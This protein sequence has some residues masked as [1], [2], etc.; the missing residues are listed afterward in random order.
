MDNLDALLHQPLRTQIAAYLA[1]SGEA[2]FSELRRELAVSDGNLESHLKKLIAAGYVTVR[3]ESGEGR[4]QSYYAL[5][6]AGLAALRVYV[7]ALQRLLAFDTA[8]SGSLP[9][10]AL[11]PNI[12][13]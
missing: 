13:M 7:A 4:P 1:G 9:S 5:T 6:E 2:A 10:G 11:K 8:E 12:A 3:K